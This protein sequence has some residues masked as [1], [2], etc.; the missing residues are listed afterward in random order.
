MSRQ[1]FWKQKKSTEW[2][3]QNYRLQDRGDTYRRTIARGRRISLFFLTHLSL[4]LDSGARNRVF[5]KHGAY[6]GHGQ[7]TA[8]I[9]LFSLSFRDYSSCFLSVGI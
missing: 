5:S 1:Y 3:A 7:A 6:G 9:Y 8:R 2:S 4:R